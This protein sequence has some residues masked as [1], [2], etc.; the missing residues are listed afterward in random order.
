M[1]QCS[2]ELGDMLRPKLALELCE[3]RLTLCNSWQLAEYVSSELR[4]TP[5]SIT[6]YFAFSIFIEL[7]SLWSLCNK[8]GGMSNIVCSILHTHCIMTIVAQDVT[9]V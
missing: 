1:G 3:P 2:G 4:R 9:L 8:V 7:N 6:A 5:H